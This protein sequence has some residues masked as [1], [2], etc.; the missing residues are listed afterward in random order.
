[1]GLIILLPPSEGKSDAPGPAASFAEACPEFAREAAAIVKK[2]RGLKT[3]AARMKAYGVST[4]EKAEAAH[5]LNLTALDAPGLPA[6]TRYTGV[7]YD[8]IDFPTLKDP[9]HALAHVYIVSAL[10]GLIPASAPI[11]NYKLPMTAALATHW[12][13]TNTARLAAMAEGHTV[14]SLLPGIHARALDFAPLL[15]VDFKLAGGKKSAGH[16]GKAIKGKFVR[17][18]LEK[19]ATTPATFTKFHEDG[20]VFDGENFIQRG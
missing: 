3:K 6:I 18:L 5:A 15:T 11:A 9:A 10:Y 17:F 16:F 2:L 7:V 13:R 1:M 4:T 8:N 20:Y 14:L 12:R 19:K